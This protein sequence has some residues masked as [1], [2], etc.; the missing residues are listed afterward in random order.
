VAELSGTATVARK[1][2]S[3]DCVPS[4]DV[5]VVAVATVLLKTTLALV[6]ARLDDVLLLSART[7]AGSAGCCTI[8]VSSVPL[9]PSHVMVT[10][11]SAAEVSVTFALDRGRLGDILIAGDVGPAWQWIDLGTWVETRSAFMWKIGAE[12]SDTCA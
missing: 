5:T 3:E 6:R 9:D 10:G 8:E 12:G 11:L 1:P 4:L 2:L 7:L